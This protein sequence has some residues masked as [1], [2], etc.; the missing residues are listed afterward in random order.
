MDGWL[1]RFVRFLIDRL[2]LERERD[3]PANTLEVIAREVEFRG[4]NL[5][6]L[7]C[8]VLVASVGL[9]VNSTAVIIGAMLISPLMGPIVGVGVGLATYDLQL[10]RKA[11]LNLAV[12]ALFSI[13]TSALYF[14][15]TP[16]K[17]AQSELWARTSPTIWDVLIAFF[18][19][20]AGIIAATSREKKITVIAGVAIATALMPPL[21]TA[22]Y[23]LARGDIWFFGGALYLFFINAVF[24]SAAAYL[25]A[26]VLRFPNHEEA[27][28][29]KQRR[30]RR[31]VLAVVVGTAVPS[32]YL[33]WNVVQ[34]SLRKQRLM[35]F[36][37]REF[38][39]PYTSVVSYDILRSGGKEVLRVVLVGE[40]LDSVQIVQRRER[41]AFYGLDVQDLEVV[42][43]QRVEQVGIEVGA[44]V[45]G[46]LYQQAER[47]IRVLE[48]SLQALHLHLMRMQ[49][50]KE[51][52]A[53][54][55]RELTVLF[56]GV[57]RVALG[58]LVV[59]D[60]SLPQAADTLSVALV[61][62]ERRQRVLLRELERWLRV[63]TNREELQLVVLQ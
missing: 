1:V 22:G 46:E 50:D 26:Q 40:P 15:L 2:S 20:L 9:N 28:P 27:L 23:G 11:L 4:V 52:S 13:A 38:T 12:A 45:L 32:I 39:L 51:L 59:H 60:A 42:Q 49:Q 14:A 54:I 62:V 17:E 61:E 8:A 47:R 19:G 6:V 21:C 43:A 33:A 7:I 44:S 29:E 10:F 24:I 34:L 18:G 63:R 58:E 31:V 5:W 37:R 57:R 3:N 56:P 16:L 25:I 48:D 30:L 36:I 53:Q 35:E 41:L 55:A